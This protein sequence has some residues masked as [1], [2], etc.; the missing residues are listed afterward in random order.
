MITDIPGLTD[1]EGPITLSLRGHLQVPASFDRK[2]YV[3]KWV[4]DGAAVNQAKQPEII[5]HVRKQA[6]GWETFMVTVDDEGKPCKPAPCT[7]ILADGKY[8][9]MCR[10]R[11]LQSAVNKLYGKISTDR[12]NL[13]A[14]G[15]TVSPLVENSG[16]LSD[17]QLVSLGAAPRNQ[18]Q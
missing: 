14:S 10:P 12:T 16:L 2:K 9:L 17:K 11:E 8:V 1:I 3:A 5:S 4:K 18:E 15:E 6:A 13:E 7:R